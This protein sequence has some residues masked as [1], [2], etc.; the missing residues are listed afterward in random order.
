MHLLVLCLLLVG[1]HLLL[2]ADNRGQ[3]GLTVVSL[4]LGAFTGTTFVAELAAK[5]GR[6]CTYF[7][8]NN[9]IFLGYDE[10]T[11]IIWQDDELKSFPSAFF[12]IG[13]TPEH[14]KSINGI[15]GSS[16][17]VQEG[18]ITFDFVTMAPYKT[19]V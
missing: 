15:L 11:R 12:P 10:A 16:A 14:P 2:R 1:Y 3:L 6:N 9:S 4:E 7:P 13:V 5:T 17:T 18:F 19:C 8:S